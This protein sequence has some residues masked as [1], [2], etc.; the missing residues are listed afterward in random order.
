MDE[1]EHPWGVY[2]HIPFCKSKCFY[3][4]FPSYAGRESFMADY[5]SALVREIERVG[6]LRVEEAGT[7][8][9]IYIGGGTPSVL[10]QELLETLLT[11]VRRIFLEADFPQGERA[12][13]RAEAGTVE[14]TMECNPGTVDMEMLKL[15]RLQGVNR[16]SFGVQSFDDRML[17]RLGRIHTGLEAMRSAHLARIAGFD[18][19]SMDLMY[20]LPEETVDDFRHDLQA[21]VELSPEHISVYGL[22]LEMG[23]AFYKMQENG[24][25]KLPDEE[26]VEAMYDLLVDF[27]PAK[28]Y[29]RYEISSFAKAG[30]ESRHNL[31]YWRD[32][33]YL[34]LG[35]AAHSY[36]GDRR[37]ENTH[38]ILAYIEGI[39]EGESIRRLEEDVTEKAHKEEFCFLALRTTEGIEKAAFART[40][41]EKLTDVYAGAI[42]D[43]KKK[44][45]L[46]ETETHVRLT[47]LGMKYGNMAFEAFLL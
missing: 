30:R 29:G 41:G 44:E 37:Y 6:A 23:T 36:L 8:A 12:R 19:I 39:R 9:T 34:G 20:G 22:Q 43:L 7:P 17:R 27:L 21:M 16:L 25:L 40:F 42:A 4:D 35:A 24:K 31:S 13:E 33:E 3:C 28:G 46:E 38:D 5:V 15:C 32:A 26:T 14:Y 10:P 11:A 18:N 1:R 2:I 45:L 47:P